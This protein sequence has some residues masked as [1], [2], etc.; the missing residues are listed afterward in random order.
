MAHGH[1]EE[2][3]GS[4]DG[5]AVFSGSPDSSRQ[6]TSKEREGNGLGPVLE[7][8]S[9]AGSGRE[10]HSVTRMLKIIICL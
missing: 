7:E 8:G 1:P 2:S 10:V 9:A 5:K 3:F 6:K 4:L